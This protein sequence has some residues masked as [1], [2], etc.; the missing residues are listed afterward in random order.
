MAARVNK[1]LHDEKTKD[2]IR[3]SQLVNFLTRAALS[4]KSGKPVD[5]GRIAAAK[6]VLPFLKPALSAVE[7]TIVD[8][9]DTADAGELELKLRALYD[10]RPELFAFL[11]RPPAPV[12]SVQTPAP[13]DVEQAKPAV[14]H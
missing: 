6:A 3:A 5:Q 14:T 8:E 10:A 9:R 12:A 1:I 11:Q 7:Q 2:A 13:A 4:E